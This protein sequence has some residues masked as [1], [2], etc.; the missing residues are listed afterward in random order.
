MTPTQSSCLSSFR[1]TL[2]LPANCVA[3]SKF[4]S[5]CCI[6]ECEGL[7]G[8]LENEI[9][10]PDATP[11]RISALVASMP[12][13]TIAMPKVL[14]PG[15]LQRLD[16]IAAGHEGMVP[17]HG[18]LFS[19]W[20]HHVYPR[21][22]PY[23][24]MSGTTDTKLPDEFMDLSGTEPTASEEEMMQYVA[25]SGNATDSRAKSQLSVEEVMPW[26]SEEELFIVRS[27]PQSW[28]STA[29][30][31]AAMRSA[32]LLAAA[33]SLAVGLIQALKMPLG[34][35]VPQKYVI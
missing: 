9:A 31:P 28:G 21:E 14:T 5:V 4:Y 10:A 27:M 34:Q 1:T 25:Q 8:H 17:L 35:S 3:S 7:L 30:T 20:L 24:H 16:D 32:V 29:S 12:S 23:P 19:Q 18:R 22:C 26:S 15:L 33:A 13:S 11:G 6:D 2:T